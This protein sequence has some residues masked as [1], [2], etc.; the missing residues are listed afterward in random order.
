[1]RTL[2]RRLTRHEHRDYWAGYSDGLAEAR[3]QRSEG[4]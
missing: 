1:M 2:W 4:Q 3:L